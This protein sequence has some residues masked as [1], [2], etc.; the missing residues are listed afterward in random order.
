MNVLKGRLNKKD[1]SRFIG[2][3][4]RKLDSSLA[5]ISNLGYITYEKI[6]GKYHFIVFGEPVKELKLG[7]GKG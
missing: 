7:N 1:M 6:K 4:S 5:R 3:K 2:V